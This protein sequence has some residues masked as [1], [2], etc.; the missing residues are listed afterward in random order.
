[1]NVSIYSHT[2]YSTYIIKNKPQ[3]SIIIVALFDKWT[4]QI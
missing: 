2:I 3:S 4:K 1:V